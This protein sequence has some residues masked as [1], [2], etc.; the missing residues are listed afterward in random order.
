MEG[1]EVMTSGIIF[2]IKRYS[3]HDGPGIRTTVFLKGCPL[4]CWWCHNPESQ[5]AFTEVIYRAERCIG[6]GACEK[7]CPGGAIRLT[8]RGYVADPDKCKG[9]GECAA[10]CPAEARE[11]VGRSIT[12]SDLAREIEKDVLF[13]EESGGG[14]TFSG[15]EPLSQPDF[16]AAALRAAR[17]LEI[18]AAV[19]TCGFAPR[20]VLEAIAPLA[21][22]FLF[23]LK[24]MDSEL[25]RKY[26]G[27]PNESILENLKWLTQN[28]YE[29]VIRI[30]V[31]P[32]I[33]DTEENI[34]AVGRFL[35]GLS[36]KPDVNLLAYHPSAVEKYHRFG[37]PYLLQDVSPPSEDCMRDISDRLEMFGLNVSTGG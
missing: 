7:A 10:V 33:N 36:R 21:R 12:A 2:D 29:T 22:L 30:P 25:H 16:L 5:S 35:S 1:N 6:C 31:I 24:L 18:H 3:I 9:S 8:Q 13:F 28:N 14:V 26:T 20:H 27:V 23:D 37:M 15:G 32:G 17:E 19:D 34:E 4:S 11:M